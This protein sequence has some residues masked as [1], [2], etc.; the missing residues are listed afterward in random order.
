MVTYLVTRSTH[1]SGGGDG[2]E[3]LSGEIVEGTA[4]CGAATQVEGALG[5]LDGHFQ[6]TP[7]ARRRGE[8]TRA[9]RHGGVVAE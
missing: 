6:R 9:S 5:L 1:C 8:R 4:S 3:L 7:G 2:D